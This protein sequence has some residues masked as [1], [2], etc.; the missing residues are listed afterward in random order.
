MPDQ[1]N[2]MATNMENPL[3]RGH[4]KFWVSDYSSLTSRSQNK[5]FKYP[6]GGVI[7][8]I[9]SLAHQVRGV[10][11]VEVRNKSTTISIQNHEAV[12]P[13]ILEEPTR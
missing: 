12:L 1:L 7:Y 8:G 9:N 11:K 5:H 13:T 2:D 6:C 3:N 10:V 4:R